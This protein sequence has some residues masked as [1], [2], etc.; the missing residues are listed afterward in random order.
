MA[1]CR[2][3]TSIPRHRQPVACCP[4]RASPHSAAGH[5][6][7]GAGPRRPRAGTCAWCLGRCPSR[8]GPGAAGAGIRAVAVGVRQVDL[9]TLGEVTLMV[10]GRQPSALRSTSTVLRLRL[11]LPRDQ[12]RRSALGGPA[13]RGRQRKGPALDDPL[14]RRL[15]PRLR[16]YNLNDQTPEKRPQRL[17]LT[18][19]RTTADGGPGGLSQTHRRRR[20]SEGGFSIDHGRP[21]TGPRCCCP[22]AARQRAPILD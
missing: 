21:T 1:R 10:L 15:H 19:L 7:G 14:P 6:V 3:G 11:Y 4:C 9:V 12:R 13:R 22:P 20:H 18:L 16:G 5:G 8:C 2:S 17:R